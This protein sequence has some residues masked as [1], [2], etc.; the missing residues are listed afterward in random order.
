[1]KESKF[2]TSFANFKAP[3]ENLLSRKWLTILKLQSKIV[4][5]EQKLQSAQEIL[6]KSVRRFDV[7]EKKE[8]QEENALKYP[9]L[10]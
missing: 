10:K 7:N 4:D 2:S 8:D 3:E 9:V 5:L 6:S 1:M